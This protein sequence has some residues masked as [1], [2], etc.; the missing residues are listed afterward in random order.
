MKIFQDT[1]KDMY[2]KTY[3]ERTHGKTR[4]LN[5]RFPPLHNGTSANYAK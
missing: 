2:N 5:G 4:N 3:Q 1:T